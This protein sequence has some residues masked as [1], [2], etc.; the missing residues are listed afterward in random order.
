MSG[1]ITG[2]KDAGGD[3][4]AI[5]AT[6][7]ERDIIEHRAHAG[8]VGD[9]AGKA[10]GGAAVADAAAGDADAHAVLVSDFLGS[11]LGGGEVH[12]HAD[13]MRTVAHYAMGHLAADAT[14]G[15]NDDD[16]LPREFHLGGH[17]LQLGF[18]ERPVFDIKGFLLRQRDVF[19][20]RLR[21]AHY[22]HRAVVKLRGYAA[23]AFV[24]TTRNH[25]ATGDEHYRRVRIAH[26]GRA[27]AF[28]VL[29]V[30]GVI[31]FILLEAGSEVLLESLDKAIYPIAAEIAILVRRERHV[32]WLDFRAQK[33]VRTTC[34][35]FRE[36]AGIFTVHKTQNRGVVLNGADEAFL[37]AHLSAQPW[38]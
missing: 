15:T 11:G 38:Q 27:G 24:F 21:A 35:Q 25:P 13:H 1:R 20:N 29:V 22:F 33:M 37:L 5:E 9:I 19:I 17:P 32:E 18:L 3:A 23:F 26:G 12:V 36:A 10:E 31:L 34:A 8:A 7:R 2:P 14:A 4:D 28:A 16:D 30:R 6:V